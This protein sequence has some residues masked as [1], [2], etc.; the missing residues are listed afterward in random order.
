MRVRSVPLQP[1]RRHGKK[2]KDDDTDSLVGKKESLSS[3]QSPSSDARLSRP[4]SVASDG[5]HG[6]FD[7]IDSQLQ[8]S[9]V[10]STVLDSPVYQGWNYGHGIN[11][12]QNL[13]GDS[14]TSMKGSW[15]PLQVSQPQFSS[16]WQNIS[17]TAPDSKF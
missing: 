11:P 14:L 17:S 12:N 4:S 13:I 10:S 9:Q 15:F 2:R 5:T 8:S 16:E 3:R 7:S 6:G 1:C